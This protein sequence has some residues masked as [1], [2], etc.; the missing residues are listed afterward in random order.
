MQSDGGPDVLQTVGIFFQ[1]IWCFITGAQ[2]QADTSS[3][4]DDTL[5]V[6]IASAPS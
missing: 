6:Q 3:Y 2:T 1:R 5:P 4:I